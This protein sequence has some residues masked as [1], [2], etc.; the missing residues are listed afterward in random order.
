METGRDYSGSYNELRDT[1]TAE[2]GGAYRSFLQN[3]K[4][5]YHKVWRDLA[6][7]YAMLV[8]ALY[9]INLSHTFFWIIVAVPVGAILIGYWVA[10][11]QLFIHEGA[12][13]NIAP[14][15]KINDRLCN[16]LICWMVGTTIKDYR[17]IH[18]Q[19]HRNLGQTDDSER[20]YFNSLNN[21][22]ILGMLLGI[23]PIRVFLLRRTLRR[24][25]APETQTKKENRPFLYGILAHLALI[26]SLI[27][28]GA[29]PSALAWIGGMG[30]FF[31]FFGAMRQLLEHRSTTADPAVDYTAIDHGALT[32]I[33]GNDFFSRTFGGAGFNKHLLH[34]WEP[35][36]S[37]TR[38]DD[39]EEYLLK[40]SIAPV[41]QSRHTTY[42]KTFI[43]LY[44]ND[45]R[46]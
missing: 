23:H 32:R 39:M 2:T 1:V 7:G 42:L 4:P 10:Y 22:F 24:Q 30:V 5:D 17:V 8:T 15:R 6:L 27:A 12:H 14:E 21:K 19:H 44:K 45:N 26:G 34:H 38:L 13:Y 35:V 37:Y 31:P 43:E 40:T 25:E 18:F 41:I 33:F 16:L 28:L 36:V 11:L 29:W 46:T 9:L 3:L 20:S